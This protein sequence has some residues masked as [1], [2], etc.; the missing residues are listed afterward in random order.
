MANLVV[1][2][3]QWGDEGKGKIVDMLTDKFDVVARSQGGHNA[4]HTVKIGDRQ[5][6][7]HLLPAGVLHQG[8][9]CIIGNGVV[10]DPKA[11]LQE[12]EELHREGITD[13][14]ERLFVSARAHV[15]LPYHRLLDRA[16]ET[17]LGA[18]KIGTTGRGI[19]PTYE[20][21][22]ARSGMVIS[23][24]LD[25]ELFKEKLLA[26][27][28]YAKSVVKDDAPELA[29]DEIYETYLRYGEQ[30]RPLVADCSLMLHQAMKA[31]KHVLYEG[32]QGTMLDIDHGTYP[33]VTSSNAC[34]GG[35]C[36]GLGVGPTKIDGVLGVIKAY[37]TRVGEGPFPTELSD[38]TGQ[39]LRDI[40]REYGATTG[41]PRRC[42]WFDAVV[43]RYA[44]RVNGASALA[45]M[46]MDILDTFPKISICTGYRYRGSVVTE[47]P[48]EPQALEA[49]EPVYEE[50][51][52][53]Q[54]STIGITEY[55]RLPENAKTY[56]SHLSELLDTEIALIST[57]PKREQTIVTSKCDSLLKFGAC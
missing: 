42:G 16:H 56:L 50:F 24:L 46:K 48:M 18:K 12:M 9:Q 10:V 31:G 51:E 25:P 37:T 3:M 23:D 30:I 35:V 44:V 47:L 28:A 22:I 53:W 40:G 33:Y 45:I 36:T 5:F 38:A 43:G 8:T 32:A 15:I 20:N 34:A 55:D 54:Q 11:L 4:G 27:L 39:L 17:E 57:G 41:R 2:G 1:L 26:N 14:D 29:F 49:C 52:G 7:L 21:K 19:G 13:F 6:V